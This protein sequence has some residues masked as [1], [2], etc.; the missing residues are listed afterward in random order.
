MVQQPR[1]TN[2]MKNVILSIL[3][4]ELARKQDFID[5]PG[6]DKPDTEI[7]RQRDELRQCVKWVEEIAAEPIMRVKCIKELE[8]FTVRKTYEIKNTLAGGAIINDEGHAV[9]AQSNI[10]EYFKV[11]TAE[12]EEQWINEKTLRHVGEGPSMSDLKAGRAKLV[13]VDTKHANGDYSE[14]QIRAAMHEENPQLA[15]YTE[16]AA[17]I[18]GAMDAGNMEAVIGMAAY[19]I[20]ND[21]LT[22][23]DRVALLEEIVRLAKS[24]LDKEFEGLRTIARVEKRLGSQYDTLIK[25]EWLLNNVPLTS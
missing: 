10:A 20:L 11:L 13:F 9:K 2:Q 7:V 23:P 4:R 12:E 5:N 15:T 19:D 16:A 24:Y 21:E 17:G 18:R 3:D 14:A 8:G 6:G 1:G 25:L 22:E